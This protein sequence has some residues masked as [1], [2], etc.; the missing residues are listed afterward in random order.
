[1]ILNVLL[2]IVVGGMLGHAVD[3]GYDGRLAQYINSPESYAIKLFSPEMIA[4][5][6][7]G[8]QGEHAGKWMYA[9]AKAY[10]R[11]GDPAVLAR[12]TSVADYLVSRQEENGYL[13]CYREDKRYY[14]RPSPEAMTVDWD[15][16]IMAYLIKGFTEAGVATGDERYLDCAQKIAGFIHW[17][18]FE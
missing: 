8:W 2:G 1:M 10:E 7:G 15:T 11:T 13:G 6:K 3:A 9:A 14:H 16:W 17:T 18:V 12:L 5:G 4:R